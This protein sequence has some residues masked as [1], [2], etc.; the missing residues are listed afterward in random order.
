MAEVLRPSTEVG[1]D[2]VL[3][4]AFEVYGLRS[5]NESLG[6]K[7]WVEKHDEWIITRLVRR[8]GFGRKEKVTLSWQEGGPGRPGPSSGPSRFAFR[9]WIRAST[10]S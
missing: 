7:A 9:T 5:P 1:G 6:F 10:M 4:L 3:G 2:E 8:L